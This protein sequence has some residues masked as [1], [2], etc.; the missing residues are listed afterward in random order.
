[1]SSPW[2][3]RFLARRWRLAGVALLALAVAAWLAIRSWFPGE[4]FQKR[5]SDLNVILITIDTL[6]ADHAGA[7]G[8]NRAN[9]PALDALAGEGVR[10][11]HC[12]CQVPLTLPS[13]VSL[14]S[15][16]YPLYNRV[17]DNGAFLVPETLQLVSE[18]LQ[19]RGMDTAAFIGAFVLHSKWGINQGFSTYSDRF[20]MGRYGKILLQNEKRAD[21]VLADATRWLGTRGKKR[22][23]AWIHLYDPHF[24]YN[25]PPPFAA[26]YP[27][28]PYRGEVEYTDSELGGFINFLKE[29]GLYDNSL[30]IVTA[31]H[32]EGLGEHG[33]TEHGM[34]LYE[35]TVHV[36]LIIRAPRPFAR[37]R[38]GETTQLVD[39]A[40]TVLDLLGIPAPG[41]WQ[42]TSLLRLMGGKPDERFGKAYS[43]TFYPRFHF[44]WSQLQAFTSRKRKYILAPRDELYDLERDPGESAELTGD[45]RRGD[46]RAQLLAFISRFSRGALGAAASSQMSVEDQRRLAA[47]G[48]LSGSV[49]VDERAP[50][51]DPKDKLAAYSALGRATALV[52]EKRWEQAVSDLRRLVGEEPE[53]ADAWSLMGN[54]YLGLGRQREALEAFRRARTLKPDNNFLMLN[55]LKTLAALGETEA[56]ASENLRFLKIFPKDASLLE[57]LGFIRLLQRR[58]D[59]ALVA[60]RQALA[61]DPAASQSFNLA[62]EALIMKKDFA[63]AEAILL[64]GR[65]ENPQAKNTRYLLAQVQEMQGRTDQALELYRQELEINPGKYQAAVNLANLLKQGG[66]PSEAARYYRMAIDANAELKMPRF[67]LAEI[68][69]QEKRDLEQAVRLCLDGIDLPPRDRDTLFGYF[70]LTNLFDALGNA[71]RRDFYTRQGEKLIADLE[72]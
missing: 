42:G 7:H 8:A 56:A 58:P 46:L 2:F 16:T 60:L 32:G 51:A 70:V 48:Y 41:Q 29:K 34:F 53:L 27:D 40:P 61:I 52:E 15:S 67:H 4:N 62:G 19:Q 64:Q 39:V 26:R 38:V 57:E 13:H 44:G 25:P 14:L 69:L 45:R 10:F 33:E 68:M 65:R 28:D 21:E 54:S 20:D 30:I 18:V 35:A 50:L 72:R 6:R 71:E 36:P 59:E 22:F 43:E 5:S 9:T 11:D 55:I 23:F 17:R 37:R 1:M 63:A 3:S 49:R 12:V 31:D 47:L 66:R 24:P